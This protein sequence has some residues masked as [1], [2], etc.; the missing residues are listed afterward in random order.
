VRGIRTRVKQLGGQ[1]EDVV[2]VFILVM[3]SSRGTLL[4]IAAAACIRKGWR[5]SK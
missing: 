4:A 3:R 2:I 5:G 1:T